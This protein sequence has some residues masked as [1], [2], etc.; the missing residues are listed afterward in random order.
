V[1][2]VVDADQAEQDLAA[3]RLACPTVVVRYGRGRMR[4]GVAFAD[5]T[6]PTWCFDRAERAVRRVARRKRSCRRCPCPGGPTRP[7]SSARRSWP[8]PEDTDTAASPVTCTDRPAPCA[9]GYGGPGAGMWSGCADAVST[10]PS[11]SMRRCWLTSIRNAPTWPMPWLPSAPRSLRGGDALP[12]TRR[13]GRSLA[14]SPAAGYSARPLP[15]DQQRSLKGP[16]CPSPRGNVNTKPRHDEDDGDNVNTECHET[17]PVHDRGQRR[18]RA[19][20]E[21]RAT[22]GSRWGHRVAALAS[23]PQVQVGVAGVEPT[24]SSS[25]SRSGDLRNLQVL[26]FALVRVSVCI[27]SGG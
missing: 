19:H 24:T 23:Y 14:C 22:L 13:R 18:P 15:V 4:L 17:T 9:G 11:S 2:I 8:K 27:G 26:E 1:I 16:V 5:S 10:G 7:R 21:R 12:G 25:R 20:H 6:P 3:G